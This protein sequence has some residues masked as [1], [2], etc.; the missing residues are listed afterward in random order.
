[1]SI[2]ITYLLACDKN[3]NFATVDR[4]KSAFNLEHGYK[5]DLH[6]VIANQCLV[7]PSGVQELILSALT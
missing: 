7:S 1:M 5:D 3:N 2:S 6:F 4:T